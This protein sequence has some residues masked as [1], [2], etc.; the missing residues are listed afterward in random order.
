MHL[1]VLGLGY[2]LLTLWGTEPAPP[3]ELPFTL[4]A[5]DFPVRQV[6]TTEVDPRSC[7]ATGYPPGSSESLSIHQGLGGAAGSCDKLA[8]AMRHRQHE[9]HGHTQAGGL[10]RIPVANESCGLDC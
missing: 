5:P 9:G 4:S 6:S 3:K 8:D 7:S 2:L 1:E 10:W